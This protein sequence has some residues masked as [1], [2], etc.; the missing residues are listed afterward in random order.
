MDKIAI[1]S[2]SIVYSSTE[3]FNDKTPYLTAIL[4]DEKGERFASLVDGYKGGV[5]VAVGQIVKCIGEDDN[6]KA[7]YS[8]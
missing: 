3:E 6:G 2:Y 4:E 7:T 8:L 1:Y 5:T